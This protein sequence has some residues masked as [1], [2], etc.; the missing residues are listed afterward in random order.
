MT[1]MYLLYQTAM[2]N[3]I[4]SICFGKR[5]EYEDEDFVNMLNIFDKNM[6]LAGSTAVVNYFP[7]LERLP[8]DPFKCRQVLE[9]VD[10]IQV[11]M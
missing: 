1:S 6:A 2:S 8:G 7:W 4:C 3:I 9:N 5:F 10:K 11:D